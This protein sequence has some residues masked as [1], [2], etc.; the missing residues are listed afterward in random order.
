[1]VF[2]VEGRLV[3]AMFWTNQLVSDG[4]TRPVEDRVSQGNLK[5][6]W[7]VAGCCLIELIRKIRLR[8]AFVHCTGVNKS[9]SS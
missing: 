7:R 4:T 9:N 1:M 6:K 3:Y 5:T 2:S 8:V